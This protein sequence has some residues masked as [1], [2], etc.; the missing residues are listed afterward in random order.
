MISV[1]QLNTYLKCP[2]MYYLRYVKKIPYKTSL[3]IVKGIAYDEGASYYQNSVIQG[4]PDAEGAIDRAVS[5]IDFADEIHSEIEWD[6]DRGAVKDTVYRGIKEYV[7][8]FAASQYP[9][10]VQHRYE[11]EIGKMPVVVIR[12]IDCDKSKTVI[13]V[14]DNKF[15]KRKPADI[16]NNLQALLYGYSYEIE[17]KELSPVISFDYCVVKKRSVDFHRVQV[18]IEDSHR[19]YISAYLAAG[20]SAINSGVWTPAPPNAWWCGPNCPYYNNCPWQKV[21]RGEIK[22][23]YIENGEIVEVK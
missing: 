21:L 16:N 10:D 5:Y 12:D 3:V 15:S 6:E 14:I 18:K 8:K 23:A 4:K 13:R 2:T 22:S 9:A 7:N 1:S 11:L 19:R 17:Y 20:V